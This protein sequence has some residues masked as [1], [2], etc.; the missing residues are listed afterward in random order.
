MK[1]GRPK[2]GSQLAASS[3]VLFILYRRPSLLRVLSRPTSEMH[4]AP[5]PVQVS[6]KLQTVP[7]KKPKSGDCN[8]YD[9]GICVLCL[10]VW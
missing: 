10:S 2:R 7:F 9:C 8:G 4:S 6:S 1:P 5:A 3:G